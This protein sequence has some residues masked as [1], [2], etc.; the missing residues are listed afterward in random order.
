MTFIEEVELYFKT[1]DLYAVLNTDKDASQ[2]DIKKAYRKVSLTVH[3]DR[4]SEDEK[5]EATK[6][7]Q[8]LARVH[9]IL[10]DEDKRNLY[11]SQGLIDIDGDLEGQ[12]DWDQYWR[13]IFPKITPDDIKNFLDNYIGSKEEEEDLIA[14]YNKLKGDMDKISDSL[15]GYD[16][17]RTRTLILD[18]IKAGKL[19]PTSKFNDDTAAKRARRAKKAQKEAIEA[20]K[21]K[22]EIMRKNG[23]KGASNMNDLTSLIQ[24]RSRSSFES[25]ISNLEAKYSK[26]KTNKRKRDA[27]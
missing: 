7:F 3:P 9:F 8:V 11:D 21:L 5:E 17:T 20:E 24:S 15:I 4:V 19:S 6:R 13:L 26:G 22:E 1:K 14:L 16:E 25:M 12:A 27:R 2:S 18:L 10:S 23:F